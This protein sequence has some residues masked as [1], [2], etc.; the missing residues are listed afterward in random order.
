VVIR[1]VSGYQRVSGVIPE[2]ERTQMKWLLIPFG[3]LT[4][5]FVWWAWVVRHGI[6]PGPS[7]RISP[8]YSGD[9]YSVPY[10]EVD[11]D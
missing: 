3:I 9:D 5:F 7:E 4:G 10:K 8:P 6:F 2:V 1:S 11:Y